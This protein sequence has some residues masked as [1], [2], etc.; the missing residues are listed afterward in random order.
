MD[1]IGLLGFVA[2]LLAILGL[3]GIIS[4]TLGV[5]IALFVIGIVLIGYF[6][7]NRSRRL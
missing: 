2:I 1:L 6:G 7:T 4:T 3:A 5:E